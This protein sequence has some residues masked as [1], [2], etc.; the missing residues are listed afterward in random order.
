MKDFCHCEKY[1]KEI[2]RNPKESTASARWSGGWC[3]L[4]ILT[5][6]R[7]LP[8]SQPVS[9]H[10]HHHHHQHRHHHQH[11]H[12]HQPHNDHHPRGL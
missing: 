8:H 9:P 2:L 6:R 3:N 4:G 7:L 10:H 5:V 12:H 1:G 11:H